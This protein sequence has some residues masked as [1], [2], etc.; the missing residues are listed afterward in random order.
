MQWRPA[1]LFMAHTI[2]IMVSQQLS[3][4]TMGVVPLKMNR[5]LKS[6]TEQEKEYLKAEKEEAFERFVKEDTTRASVFNTP[7]DYLKP[8]KYK[9][10]YNIRQSFNIMYK[11]EEVLRENTM[12]TMRATSMS[13]QFNANPRDSSK[14]VPPTEPEPVA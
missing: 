9:E 2:L 1:F 6:K 4:L 11:E 7:F 5:L 8:G 12:L 3:M 14:F 13:R 10:S